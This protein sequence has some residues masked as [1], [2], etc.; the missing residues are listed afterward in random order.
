LPYGSWKPRGTIK[1]VE[2]RFINLTGDSPCELHN[3]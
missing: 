2:N 3:H 1:G